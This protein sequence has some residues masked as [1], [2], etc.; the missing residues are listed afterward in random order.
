MKLVRFGKKGNERPGIWIDNEHILDVRSVAFHV[1]DFNE[2][3]FSNWGLEQLKA[4]LTDPCATYISS[5]NIRLGPPISRPSKIICVGANYPAHAKEF[6][7]KIPD[8]P[9]LFSKATTALIGPTDPIV[10]PAHSNTVDSEA[11]IAVVISK[12]TRNISANEAANHIAGYMLMNDVTDREAQRKNG[13][14]FLGKS[15]DTFCPAG[16]FLVT[17]DE[18]PPAPQIYIQQEFNNISLQKA[19]LSDIQF[20]IPFLIEY[21]SARITLLPGDVISTGTPPGIGSARNPQILMKPNDVVKITATGL[22][23]QHNSVTITSSVF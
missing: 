13:Q 12:R 23:F 15:A 3:F 18:L 22:G 9:I 1:K 14:W 16:P 6:G 7:H 11:E 10:L 21:I 19:Q 20:S 4:L 5:K 8:E 2:H 17:P